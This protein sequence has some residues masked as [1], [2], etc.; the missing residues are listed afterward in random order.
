VEYAIFSEVY[1]PV[2][3]QLGSLSQFI[4]RKLEA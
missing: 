4:V 1:D 2:E 3:G